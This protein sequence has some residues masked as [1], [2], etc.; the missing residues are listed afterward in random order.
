MPQP[1]MVNQT[2]GTPGS[3][4]TT[5]PMTPTAISSKETPKATHIPGAK[6]DAHLRL[7]D[8][9]RGRGRHPCTGR[10]SPEEPQAAADAAARGGTATAAQRSGPA[11][12]GGSRAARDAPSTPLGM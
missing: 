11:A 8:M 12:G 5:V 3:T 2:S 9:V 6:G 10:G 7:Q 1:S 4:G